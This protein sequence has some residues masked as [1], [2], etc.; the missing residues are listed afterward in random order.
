ME[1]LEITVEACIAHCGKLKHHL[2]Q[3]GKLNFDRYVFKKR[4]HRGK[5]KYGVN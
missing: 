2:Y 5:N 3:N 4:Y 1:T